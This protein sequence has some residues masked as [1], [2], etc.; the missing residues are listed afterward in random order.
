MTAVQQWRQYNTADGR[1]VELLHRART[2]A[3]HLPATAHSVQV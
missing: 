3:L 2:C 1:L